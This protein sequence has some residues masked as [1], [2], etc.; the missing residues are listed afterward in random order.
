MVNETFTPNYNITQ[1]Q[2]SENILEFMQS[3]NNLTD[4]T[5]MLGILIAGF[6]ILFFS[7]YKGDARNAFI[8]SGF[9]TVVLAVFF[10]TLDFISPAYMIVMVLVYSAAATVMLIKN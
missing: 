3:V 7:M 10:A 9:I 5:F 4:G 6:V 2:D 8:G 1:F